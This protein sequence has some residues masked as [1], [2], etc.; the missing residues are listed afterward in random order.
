MNEIF[1]GRVCCGFWVFWSN[2]KYDKTGEFLR[3]SFL[4]GEPG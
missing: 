4:L 1:G 3:N 2:S